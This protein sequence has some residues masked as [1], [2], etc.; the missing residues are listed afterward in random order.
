MSFTKQIIL[1]TANMLHKYSKYLET[2]VKTLNS[3]FWKTNKQTKHTN[4]KNLGLEKYKNQSL[5][6]RKITV[7]QQFIALHSHMCQEH[8]HKNIPTVCHFPT[9]PIHF[10]WGS[11]LQY[12]FCSYSA[13]CSYCCTDHWD[14]ILSSRVAFLPK[15]CLFTGLCTLLR[16][17]YHHISGH[18]AIVTDGKI[19]WTCQ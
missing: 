11:A 4:S 17:A 3:C 18:S 1:S 5:H 14:Q 13:F 8:G 9:D 19:E 2:T 16:L 15:P 6:Y 10:N 12:C 7:S